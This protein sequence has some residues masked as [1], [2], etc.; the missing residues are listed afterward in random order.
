V[1][2]QFRG[3]GVGEGGVSVSGLV[4]VFMLVFVFL[5][6]RPDPRL[7][8]IIFIGIMLVG[9]IVFILE[10]VFVSIFMLE[11]EFMPEFIFEFDFPPPT[12]ANVPES[13]S[14]V[15]LRTAIIVPSPMAGD[16]VSTFSWPLPFL[17]KAIV[18]MFVSPTKTVSV[19]PA[20][21]F[22]ERTST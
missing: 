7:V 10:C 5:I 19:V 18:P 22:T 9:S 15:P 12:H 4:F 3:E 14:V 13:T 1:D 17:G 6:F 11:F 16:G 8:F 20:G 2:R 21:R